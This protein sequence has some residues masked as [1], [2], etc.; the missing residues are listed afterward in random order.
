MK[1]WPTREHRKWFVSNVDMSFAIDV[2]HSVYRFERFPLIM[3]RKRSNAPSVSY[4]QK[5]PIFEDSFVTGCLFAMK[6]LFTHYKQSLKR[7]GTC[8]N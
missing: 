6:L 4:P 1:K 3:I 5:Q 8:E 2:L 7:R